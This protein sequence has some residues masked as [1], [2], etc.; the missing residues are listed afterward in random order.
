MKD[1]RRSVESCKPTV[2]DCFQQLYFKFLQKY[3]SGEQK[4][5]IEQKKERNNYQSFYA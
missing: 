2:S 5:L 4:E 3:G 1:L